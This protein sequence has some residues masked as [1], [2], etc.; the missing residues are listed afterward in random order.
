M[1]D[2]LIGMK[3]CFQLLL[4]SETA[5]KD[6]VFLFSTE[7]ISIIRCSANIISFL[8]FEE[9]GKKKLLEVEDI[10]SRISSLVSFI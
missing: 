9:V 10:F 7:D 2:N 1:I 3:H 6:L 8:S 5:I 4:K